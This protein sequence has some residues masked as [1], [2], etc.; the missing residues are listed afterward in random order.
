MFSSRTAVLLPALGLFYAPSMAG[1]EDFTAAMESYLESTI[2]SFANHD[3]LVEAIRSQNAETAGLTQADIDALDSAWRSEIGLSERPTIDPV[4][5]NAASDFLRG[6]VAD[7]GGTITEV[8]IMDARGLNV[9]TSG[10]TSDYWQGDEAKHS[11]TYPNGA[12]AVHFSEIEFDESS[13]SYQGQISL[14]IVDPASNE[15]VGAMTVGVDAEA[16]F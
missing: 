12:G 14:S 8:F 2:N 1:A 16:L 15:V 13:Q 4:L 6:V 10:V 9:A 11:E 5:N 3:V 7:A